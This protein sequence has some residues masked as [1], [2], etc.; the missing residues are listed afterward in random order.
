MNPAL[1]AARHEDRGYEA[2]RA[3]AFGHQLRRD[4]FLSSIDTGATVSD[5]L[6]GSCDAADIMAHELTDESLENL[7][8][9]AIR[10][11][12]TDPIAAA[13][14]LSEAN[15]YASSQASD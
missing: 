9:I 5:Y 7:I 6:D 14:I 3:F 4:E 2:S 8:L 10:A 15:R 11:A 1:D 12:K 13:F